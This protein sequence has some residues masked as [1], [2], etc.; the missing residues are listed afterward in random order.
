MYSV[1]YSKDVYNNDVVEF[2][3]LD[4]AM[5]Y[6]KQLGITVEISTPSY[7]IVGRF[8]VDEIKNGLTPDGHEYGWV[9]RRYK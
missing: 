6:A 4:D 8:G 2:Q 3:T 5:Q 9:K 7:Q 1:K